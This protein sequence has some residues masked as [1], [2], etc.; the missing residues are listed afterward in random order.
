MT[1]S[2]SLTKKRIAKTTSLKLEKE[3]KI[4][5]SEIQK[6]E[7]RILLKGIFSKKERDVYRESV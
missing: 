5:N 1:A 7:K 6:I 2:W 4:S 3:E